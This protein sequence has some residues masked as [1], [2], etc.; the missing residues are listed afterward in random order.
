MSDTTDGFHVM[1][2]LSG[3]SAQDLNR[4]LVSALR[5]VEPRT[6]IRAEWATRAVT[7]RF[8]D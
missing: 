1:A 5:H 2:T 4:S 7:V 6:R 8:F 3:E